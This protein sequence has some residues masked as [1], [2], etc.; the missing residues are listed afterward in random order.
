MSLLQVQ[1]LKVHFP[2]QHGV[3]GRAHAFVKAVD[4]VSF[5]VEANETVRAGR[6]KR[7]RQD[8]PRTRLRRLLEPTSGRIDFE[9]E[10]TGLNGAK[11]RLL[12]RKFQ[13]V[14]RTPAARSIRA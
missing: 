12:R 3:F 2:V 14:S 1:N 7:L 9:G 11:L 5:A 4:D 8:H 10:I 13:M 6:R